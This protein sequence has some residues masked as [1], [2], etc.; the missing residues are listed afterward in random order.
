MYKR[1]IA[2]KAAQLVYQDWEEANMEAM[3][4]AYANQQTHRVIEEVL[5]DIPISSRQGFG[6]TPLARHYPAGC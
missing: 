6:K 1:A 3:D 5:G 4:F 2:L